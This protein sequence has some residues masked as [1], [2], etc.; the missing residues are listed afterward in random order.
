MIAVFGSL[1][2]EVKLGLECGGKMAEVGSEK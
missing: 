2:E 1:E